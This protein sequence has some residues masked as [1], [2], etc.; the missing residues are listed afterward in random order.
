MIEKQLTIGYSPCPNDTHIFYALTHGRVPL[1]GWRPATPV[2]ADV[3]TLNSW[4]LAGR[5]DITK[6][7]FHALAHVLDE[8]V[9]LRSG[10]ALGRGCGPLLVASHAM[11]RSELSR[12]RVAIPGRYTTAALLL[13]LFAPGC[14]HTV[15]MP[16]DRIMPAIVAG[17]VN[18][19]V[20]IHESRFTYP[21]YGLSLVRD[22]GSWWEE[23]SGRPIPLGGI[24]A[25]R[26]LGPELLGRIEAAI[27][28]SVCWAGVH[29]DACM[30]YIRQHAREME[31]RVVRDHINL[32]VNRFSEDLGDEG[33][34]AVEFFLNQGRE[35]GGLPLSRT[36]LSI[37]S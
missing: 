3:E 4:A 22:L 28:K 27:R 14:D 34:A 2:L 15:A 13:K 23:F 10:A 21:R 19:G 31:E 20:I 8:Y 18:A 12:V 11:D 30:G 37:N 36:P 32:Y 26:S 25:R 16:F 24:V 29:P 35:I 1:D 17:R 5:L 33:L 6:L 7:S 9:L